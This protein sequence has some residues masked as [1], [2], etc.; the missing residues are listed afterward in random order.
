[1]KTIATITLSMFVTT[2]F[3]AD[4]PK[5]GEEK[6]PAASAPAKDAKAAPAPAAA[7]AGAAKDA[8]K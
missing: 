5:K 3:A 1:M 8:K 4:A 7:P 2:A 6:K